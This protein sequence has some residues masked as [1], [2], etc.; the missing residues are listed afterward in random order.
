M[1]YTLKRQS[2][3]HK[4]WLKFKVNNKADLKVNNKAM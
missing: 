2:I 3:M 4:N 1:P